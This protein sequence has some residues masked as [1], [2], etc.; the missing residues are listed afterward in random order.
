MP[1]LAASS[2]T[3]LVFYMARRQAAPM[4]AALIAAGR[5]A[6][7]A[8]AFVADASTPAQRVTMAT[9]A[10][11]GEVATRLPARPTLIVVGPVLALRDVLAPLQQTQPMAAAA[12][13]LARAS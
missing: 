11:A 9:L 10:T 7:E 4:A 1:I 6:T 12:P 3:S 8:V 5:P 2:P 13:A